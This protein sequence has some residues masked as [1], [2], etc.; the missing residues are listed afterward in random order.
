MRRGTD[1]EAT[2]RALVRQAVEGDAGAIE[3]LVRR[4]Q[5]DVHG[6]AVRMLWCPDDAADATQE[7]LMKVVT[8]L[9]SFRGESA[10]R[11]WVYRIAVNHSAWTE[12]T[13]SRT[14]SATCSS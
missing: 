5:D 8:R 7:I 3:T 6:L 12:R 1:D 4:V 10:F 14:S 2:L 11:T 13:A 9:A